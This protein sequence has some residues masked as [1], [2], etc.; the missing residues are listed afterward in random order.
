M[1]KAKTKARTRKTVTKTKPRA[2]QSR[3]PVR[4]HTKAP[5]AHAWPGLPPGYF[6][7]TR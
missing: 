6:D 4:V 5:A 2:A 3:T 1:A 7:R